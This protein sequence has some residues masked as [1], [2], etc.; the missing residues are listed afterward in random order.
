MKQ[1]QNQTLLITHKQLNFE[2]IQFSEDIMESGQNWERHTKISERKAQYYG[3]IDPEKKYFMDKKLSYV[4]IHC[5]IY[6]AM[7]MSN[8]SETQKSFCAKKEYASSQI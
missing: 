4:N 8:G 5:Q 6:T 2:P 1:L 3:I 7:E